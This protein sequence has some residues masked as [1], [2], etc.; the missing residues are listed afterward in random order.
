M[1][2]TEGRKP[3]RYQPFIAIVQGT[4]KGVAFERFF[5]RMDQ[6]ERCA[7]EFR[8][9]LIDLRDRSVKTFY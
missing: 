7:R 4:D 3:H 6:A 8:G 9:T 1:K 5:K 2:C